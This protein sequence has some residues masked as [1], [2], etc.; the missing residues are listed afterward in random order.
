MTRDQ[1][2]KCV[3]SK[4]ASAKTL[5]E[6]ALTQLL[7]GHEQDATANMENAAFY[8]KDARSLLP[9]PA[10]EEEKCDHKWM[11][12]QVVIDS[13]TTMEV[14]ECFKCRVED[15]TRRTT[16]VTQKQRAGDEP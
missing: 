15:L 1:T 3:Y 7:L 5:L 8:V 2:T 13:E 11:G 12:R 10:K 9:L 16:T 14:W 6:M 4:L